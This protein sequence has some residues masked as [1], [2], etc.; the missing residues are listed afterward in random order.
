MDFAFSKLVHW[1][2]NR[3]NKVQIFSRSQLKGS[4][5]VTFPKGTISLSVMYILDQSTVNVISV[6]LTVFIDGTFY[7]TV[8]NLCGVSSSL[9]INL[10]TIFFLDRDTP[11]T[12]QLNALSLRTSLM[13]SVHLSAPY[14]I[15]SGTHRYCS[16]DYYHIDQNYRD[17]QNGDGF[18]IQQYF[19]KLPYCF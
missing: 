4:T 1:V 10:I 19:L 13:M 3:L 11:S 9:S 5:C 2:W 16:I 6:K 14:D 15:T 7:F 12:A 8:S 18:R 17:K